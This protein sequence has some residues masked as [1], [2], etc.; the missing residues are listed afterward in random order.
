[1]QRL[2]AGGEEARCC[3]SRI[4]GREDER[5]GDDEREEA[6]LEAPLRQKGCADA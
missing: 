5:E 2:R 3:H 6:E 4:G 1:M